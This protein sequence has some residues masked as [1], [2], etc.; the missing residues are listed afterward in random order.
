MCVRCIMCAFAA[1]CRMAHSWG[2]RMPFTL[3]YSGARCY[4]LFFKEE[5]VGSVFSLNDGHPQRWLAMIHDRWASARAFLPPPFQSKQHRF[6][7]LEE[8]QA[9]LQSA[10][11]PKI[12]GRSG[13]RLAETMPCSTAV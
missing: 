1:F 3:R 11:H 7:T 10:S 2:N 12:A 8:L 13:E 4:T 5:H 6:A 9:W